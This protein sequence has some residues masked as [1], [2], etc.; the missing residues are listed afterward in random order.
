MTIHLLPDCVAATTTTV[1]TQD[2]GDSYNGLRFGGQNGKEK[3]N[4]EGR[5]ESFNQPKAREEKFP[6]IFEGQQEKTDYKMRR[7]VGSL[8]FTDFVDWLASLDSLLWPLCVR[9]ASRPKGVGPQ[10]PQHLLWPPPQEGS[11]GLGTK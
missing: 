10:K 6:N 11:R 8:R 7:A 3:I 4:Y 1:Q 9:A 5:F 2:I